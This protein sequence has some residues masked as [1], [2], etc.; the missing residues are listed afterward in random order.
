MTEVHTFTT[1]VQLSGKSATG[2]EV[3][4][5]VLAALDGGRRPAVVV[6]VGN[7][8][9]RTTIGTMARRAMLPLSAE[10]RSA[11][12]V[13][14]GQDV[15]VAVRLDNEERTVALPADLAGALAA[16]ERARA[17]FETCAPSHRK[18]W[19]RWVEEAKRPQTRASRVTATVEALREGRRSRSG[20]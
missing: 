6:T 5:G 16:D 13:V 3:P 18:E 2:L 1:T 14:A 4:P 12:A 19:V 9:Y 10:H 20:R 15:Q 8:T 7:H 11:A 17:T